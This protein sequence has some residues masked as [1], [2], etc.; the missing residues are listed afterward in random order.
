LTKKKKAQRLEPILWQVLASALIGVSIAALLMSLVEK[1]PAFGLSSKGYYDGQSLPLKALDFF[2]SL[3]HRL[4][5]LVLGVDSNGPQTQRFIGTRSDTM[6]LVGLDPANKKVSVISIPRDT[7]VELSSINGGNKINAAY[8]I[9]GPQL[10]V[11]VVQNLLDVRIDRYMVVDT[12]GLKKILDELG[13][14]P[15]LVE[16]PMHYVDHTAHLAVDLEPGMQMLNADQAEGYIRYR[17]DNMGD[18]GRIERQQWLL[19][20]LWPKLS[21]PQVL[22]KLPQL[23]QLAD[24]YVVTDLSFEE[25]M[26]AARFLKDFDSSRLETAMLPGAPTYIDGLSYWVIDTPSSRATVDRL[27][28]TDSVSY[29]SDDSRLK[30]II[31]YPRGC[32]SAAS[33]LESKLNN[34]GYHVQY[35][36][37]ADASECQ[38]AQI[39]QRS[40]RAGQSAE[41]NLSASVK[42]LTGWPVTVAIE[43]RPASDF[44]LVMSPSVVASLERSGETNALA[45]KEGAV[46]HWN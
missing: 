26:K 33:Y 9:G 37:A 27:M 43:S 18:I 4:N 36:C 46:Q 23:F 41:N 10:A 12:Q 7:K 28:G 24:Q 15:V 35:R 6:M 42:E 11:Q 29:A 19:R 38:H 31:K 20:Q 14:I 1:K 44:T 40:T 8:A 5:L 45:V 22:L 32:D 21:E 39:I 16:K 34:A 3:D 17:H 2:P 30:I 13:P 25:M